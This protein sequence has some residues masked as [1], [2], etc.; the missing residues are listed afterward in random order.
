MTAIAD[1]LGTIFGRVA[2]AGGLLASFVAWRAWDIHE[3]RSI[4]EQRAQA[5]MEKTAHANAS[6]ADKAARATDAIP[7]GRLRDKFFRD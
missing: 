1:F 2:L 6:K 5:Q 3:Q 7:D 4:G